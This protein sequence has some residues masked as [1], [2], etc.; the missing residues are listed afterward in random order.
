[1][2]YG[3]GVD[4]FGPN[5]KI[6]FFNERGE[7]LDKWKIAHS[8]THNGNQILPAVAEEIES[9]MSR[10]RLMEDDILGVGVG[11]PGPV[12]DSGVVNKCVNLGWGVFNIDRAL[13]G[14]TG[15]RVRS[16]N[17]ANL[18]A[19]GEYWQG[20]GSK[21]MV[22]AAM[23]T[24]LGGAIICNGTLING[25]H[26]G[27][28]EIGHMIVNVH[29]EEHCTCGRR[30]CVEQYCSPT[31]IV[32][33][34]RRKL[35]SSQKP[36]VLRSARFFDYKTVLNA[37]NQG[38]PLALEVMSQVYR[39]VG[40]AL[41]NICCVTNPDT[42]VLGGEFCKI[43]RPALEIIERYFHQYIFHA[44]QNVSFRLATLDTDAC[45]YGAFKLVLDSF[46]GEG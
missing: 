5:I 28:G 3:F 20:K 19:L 11:I 41:A 7:L 16:S 29:E 13:S 2:R 42:V 30:G 17:I 18:S 39:Y 12:N 44:N 14:L 8:V 35:T 21:N 22:F 1:M 36:S 27:G 34:T 43:G 25:A 31:G 40:Q 15:L 6:G 46:A 38:D 45:I 10:K 33:L 4:I 9:Y 32:R 24:G 37:A 26:G 23:N